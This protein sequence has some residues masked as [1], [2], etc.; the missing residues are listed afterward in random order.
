LVT[1]LLSSPVFVALAIGVAALLNYALA[2][3]ALRDESRQHLL[4]R[5]RATSPGPMVALVR[6]F[7]MPAVVAWLSFFVDGTT[8]QVV[9]GGY[10]VMQVAALA[11]NIDSAMRVR[12]LLRPGLAEGRLV[13]SREYE[14]RSMAARSVGMAAFCGAVAL[15]FWS[16]RLPRAAS[17]YSQ[18]R[19]VGIGARIKQPGKALLE[20]AAVARGCHHG[21]R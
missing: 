16:W 7:G 3:V 6:R 14:Y 8:R 5:A 15:L 21:R 11:M 2:A 20:F 4:E 9:A 13:V 19:S 12:A 10:L 17:F 1:T 18:P